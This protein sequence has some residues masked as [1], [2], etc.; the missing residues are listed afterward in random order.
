MALF[1]EI[2]SGERT[3]TR[4]LIKD[5]FIIGRRQGHLTIEDSKVSGQHAK[6]EERAGGEIW[7]VDLGSQNAI[8]DAENKKVTELRLAEGTRF[9]LGRTA[10]QVVGGEAN[11]ISEE[12]QTSAMAVTVTRTYW[13]TLKELVLRAESQGDFQDREI[14]P[15]F[16][17]LRLRFTRGLQTGTEWSIGY[18]PRTVGTATV[19]LHLEDPGLPPI[20]FRLLPD[21]EGV[22]F[23]NATD[24]VVHLNGKWVEEGLLQN[25]DVIDIVNTQLQVVFDDGR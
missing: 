3:G 11:Q 18:G 8:R 7:L 10:F 14:T 9:T 4:A 22:R 5:G 13:D 25:G 1:L 19:D 24:R 23:V 20:C 2:A 17:I 15:F 21:A 6:I 12:L 16:R